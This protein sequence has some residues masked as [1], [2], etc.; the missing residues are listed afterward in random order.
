MVPKRTKSS[1]ALA[2][3]SDINIPRA[4]YQPHLFKHIK[5]TST[6]YKED[7][8]PLQKEKVESRSRNSECPST[9][10]NK[11]IQA[12]YPFLDSINKDQLVQQSTSKRK[13]SRSNTNL[14]TLE[15]KK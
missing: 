13:D 3:E 14:I 7:R 5:V 6:N 1:E 2:N 8:V 10:S 15:D 12:F 4:K 11:D 9:K